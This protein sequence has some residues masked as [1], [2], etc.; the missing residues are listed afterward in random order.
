MQTSIEIARPQ[1]EIDDA[2]RELLQVQPEKCTIVHCKFAIDSG[3]MYRI[4][5]HTF[6]IEDS[7]SRR[8][9]IKAFNIS[10]MP[11]WTLYFDATGVV[12]FTLIFEGLSCNCSNFTLLEDIPESGGFYSEVIARNSSDVYEVTVQSD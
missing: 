4:W 1:V 7:G 12:R 10:L 3:S 9:L 6:L 8:G 11:N 5:P 2:I